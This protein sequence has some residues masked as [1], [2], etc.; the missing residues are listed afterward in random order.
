V[1]PHTIAR[2]RLDALLDDGARRR[3]VTVV[4]DAGFGKSTL[5]ASWAARRPCA[6]Y[7]VTADDGSLAAMVAGLIDALRLQVPALSASA[8]PDGTRGPDADAEQPIRALAYASAIAD[9][10]EANLTEDLVLVLDDLHEIGPGD[11]AARLVEGLVRVAPPQLHI[12]IASRTPAPFRVERLRGRGQLLEIDGSTLA[13]TDEETAAVLQTVLGAGEADLA[14]VLHAAVQGWPA[15]ARLAGE[16]LRA[17]PPAERDTRLRRALRPGGP[18]FDYLAEEVF[19]SE[20]D[21]VRRLVAVAAALP[22]VSAELCAELGVPDGEAL[23]ALEARGFVTSDE[24]GESYRLH[25][26]LRDFALARLTLDPDDRARVVV[27]AAHWSA[28]QGQD[29]EALALFRQAGATGEV[30]RLLIDRG[31]ALVARG[32][33]EDVVAAIAG[34][35]A[36][37]RDDAIVQLDGEARQVLGDWEGARACFERLVGDGPI[38]AAIAWRLGLIHY[39]RGE[40]AEAL[41]TYG[42][43]VIDGQWPAEEARLLAWWASAHWLRGE[44]DPARELAARALT[45]AKAAADDRALAVA[46]TVLAMLAATDSDPRANAANYLRGLDHAERAGDALQQIR[47]RVNRG[48]HYIAEARYLQGIAEVDVAIRIADLAGFAMFRALAMNNRGE[49]LLGLGR[50]DE[51]IAE[52]ERSRALYQRTESR[53]VASPLANLGEVYRLRG[54]LAMA[55]AS[56]EEAVAVAEQNQYVQALVPA[57]AGLARI[58]VEDEPDAALELA[59]RAVAI[60]TGLGQVKALLGLGWVTLQRGDLER[61]GEAAGEAAALCRRRRDKAGL[62]EA[63][64]LQAAVVAQGNGQPKPLLHEAATIHREI[65]D[66]LG[67]ARVELMLARITSGDGARELALRAHQ[68]F[69]DA[70]ASRYAAAALTTDDSPPVRIECLGGFRV[71][72]AGR[73]V[74]LGDWPSRK[75]R[76]LLKILV[77]RRCRPVPRSQLVDLLWPDDDETVAAPR[78]SVALSTVRSVLDPDKRYA[79]DRFVRADRA[80]LWLDG[81]EA[82]VDVEE[83]LRDARAGLEGGGSSRSV[84]VLRAA[85]AAYAGDFLEEDV[86]ADW[87]SGLRDEARVAYVR[88]ARTLADRAAASGDHDGAAGYL[89]RILQRDVYDERAHLALVRS[90]VGGG[91]HGE[92]RRAYRAYVSRMEELGVEPAPFPAGPERDFKA[93]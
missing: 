43:G 79:A 11:P 62:A 34:L 77:A 86:Y 29:R 40:L 18:V 93:V 89:L 68:R 84:L 78:L 16:A 88:V 56:Y 13:F 65:G 67:E 14:E 72:R 92:A 5:L 39:V 22:S 12:V 55:R 37:L 52:L 4:A 45:E 32:D 60:G 38:P 64:E 19:A 48:S 53:L 58:L 6:W 41:A 27:R 44:F 33:A 21:D 46:H 75:A 7:T 10:L 82:A 28:A 70:G 25:P 42:R 73:P 47:I 1:S 90:F 8:L 9:S 26:L 71:L 20:P 63:L 85:E 91:A 76:D 2:P 24:N 74:P 17:V 31:P 49:A 66:P 57:L 30:A 87:A 23:D 80:A 51:A 36:E 69:L 83:F 15:A 59:E 50:L 35:P 3:L 54:D 61:A 81:T